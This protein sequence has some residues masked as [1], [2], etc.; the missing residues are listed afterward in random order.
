MKSVDRFNRIYLH[1]S[2]VDFRKYINGLSL[3][4]EQYMDLSPFDD[5]LFC[6]TNKSRDQ[7]RLLYWDQNGFSLWMKR[8][9]KDRFHWP[10]SKKSKHISIDKR[11]LE[12]LLDGVDIKKIKTHQALNYQSLY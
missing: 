12:W 6:F 7:I 11:Q 10:S 1:G 5:A 8:L 2:P 3:L 4:V 9:E